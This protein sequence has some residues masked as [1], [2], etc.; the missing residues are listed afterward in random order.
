MRK[1]LITF[2]LVCLAFVNSAQARQA[3]CREFIV[4]IENGSA[5][6]CLL[7]DQSILSG[8]PFEGSQI[9]NTLLQGQAIQFVMTSKFKN[10]AMLY[11]RYQCGED[12][13]ELLSNK[14][15]YDSLIMLSIPPVEGH[16]LSKNKMDA[17]FSQSP[18]TMCQVWYDTAP[19]EIS[20]KILN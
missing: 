3:G 19:A 1:I 10:T 14:P 13:I 16:V 6:D 15:F 20:W 5:N 7:K 8:V 2:V 17:M 18:P 9:P 11:L 12:E 4:N